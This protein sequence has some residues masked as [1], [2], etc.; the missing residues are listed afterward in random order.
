M[1]FPIFLNF[2]LWEVMIDLPIDTVK[3]GFWGDCSSEG[4]ANLE[5]KSATNLLQK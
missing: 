3:L 2:Q 4:V 1:I 5:A